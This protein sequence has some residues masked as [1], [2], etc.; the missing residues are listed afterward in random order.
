MGD[1]YD[2]YREALVVETRTV[3]PDDLAGV[4]PDERERLERQLHAE[5]AEAAELAYVRLH[6]GFCRQITVTAEDVDRLK[7]DAGRADTP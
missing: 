5:P 6:T 2:R 7:K 4:G 3:W 1:K